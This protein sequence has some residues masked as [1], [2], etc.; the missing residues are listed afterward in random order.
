MCMNCV[1]VERIMDPIFYEEIMKVW[2]KIRALLLE[3]CEGT[4]PRYMFEGL[5]DCVY[6]EGKKAVVDA[7]HSYADCKISPV[8][9][10]DRIM[11][12]WDSI[13]NLLMIEQCMGTLPRDIFE[14]LVD[15]IY[16]LGQNDALDALATRYSRPSR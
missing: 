5:V 8:L 7:D 4:L 14:S 15:W 16:D 13:R 9:Y 1:N 3:K 11:T 2:D 6:C 10:E 12:T